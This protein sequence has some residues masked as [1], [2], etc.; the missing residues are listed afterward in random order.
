MAE[1]VRLDGFPIDPVVSR[2]AEGVV[3]GT[4][5]E[6]ARRAQAGWQDTGLTLRLALVRRLGHL[7]A[8]HGR[9]LAESALRVVGQ[10]AAEK[11]VSEVIPLADAC[12]FLEREAARLLRP[13]P[14]G[15]AG[16]RPGCRACR[17]RSAAS[18]SA[19]CS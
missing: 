17:P 1:A 4:L 14:L 18:L 12:R 2:P 8:R 13:R 16:G 5:I 9:E 11:L 6:R 7:I 10:H 15:G 3:P 19:S